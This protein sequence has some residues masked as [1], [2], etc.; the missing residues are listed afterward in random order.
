VKLH[1]IKPPVFIKEMS[2]GRAAVREVRD[3]ETASRIHLAW[4][5]RG[6]AWRQAAEVLSEALR[7]QSSADAARMAFVAA[8]KEAKVDVEPT[9]V[10]KACP[11]CKDSRFVCENHPRLSWPE[12]CSCGAGDACVAD[13]PEM[14]E[15]FVRDEDADAALLAALENLAKR[16]A[17]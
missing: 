9:E 3:V 6:K 17:E 8:A 12:E 15:N 13:P 4:P 1:P 11:I 14:P 16:D 10:P 2:A 5:G 7:G